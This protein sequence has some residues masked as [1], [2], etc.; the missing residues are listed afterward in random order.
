MIGFALWAHATAFHFL[1]VL[2]GVVAV[3]F[4]AFIGVLFLARSAWRRRRRWAA[5]V[6]RTVAAPVP[7]P[8]AAPVREAPA[9]P[10]SP[11]QVMGEAQVLAQAAHV[12]EMAVGMCV[13]AGWRRANLA[14]LALLEIEPPGARAAAHHSGR[15]ERSLTPPQPRPTKETS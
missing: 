12:T 5:A 3:G 6:R 14:L 10:V 9:V 1:L 8:Q 13:E 2:A 11:P 15:R 7:A 4:A